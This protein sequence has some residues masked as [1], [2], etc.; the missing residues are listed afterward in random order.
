[1][2]L[3]AKL[4]FA[5]KPSNP[6]PSNGTLIC[7]TEDRTFWAERIANRSPLMSQWISHST[8]E[9]P[10]FYLLL[11]PRIPWVVG[12]LSSHN[13]N[14]RSPRL[15]QRTRS[16]HSDAE[17]SCMPHQRMPLSVLR[18][19]NAFF[20]GTD[21]QIL[22]LWHKALDAFVNQPF[23]ERKSGPLSVNMVENLRSSSITRRHKRTSSFHR[24]GRPVYYPLC[25]FLYLLFSL[26]W[27]GFF[28]VISESQTFFLSLMDHI[29]IRIQ[30]S[31]MFKW[32]TSGGC[33]VLFCFCRLFG[34]CIGLGSAMKRE[35]LLHVSWVQ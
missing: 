23:A 31:R 4:C 15:R 27:K 33:F 17:F 21:V 12:L 5:C 32:C 3:V 1:M 14:I 30:V 11:D 7:I 24:M 19:L 9:M 34:T 35:V 10:T 22:L 8:T 26:D 6:G 2:L 28:M 29:L 13:P 25:S 16:I 20:Q 18:W